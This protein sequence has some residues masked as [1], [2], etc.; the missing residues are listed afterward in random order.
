MLL[1]CRGCTRPGISAADSSNRLGT[2]LANRPSANVRYELLSRTD[3][4]QAWSTVVEISA[5]LPVCVLG[6][7][8]GV[9][10][11]QFFML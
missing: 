10:E 7:A 11:G 4:H 8:V 3:L 9:I 6:G 2:F 5:C 1:G